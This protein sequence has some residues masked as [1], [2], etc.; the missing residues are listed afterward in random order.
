MV[1]L[2]PFVASSFSV[3]RVTAE[4]GGGEHGEGDVGIGAAL[5]RVLLTAVVLLGALVLTSCGSPPPTGV[6]DQGVADGVPR[7]RVE[8]L[9]RLPHDPA[10]FT[11]GLELARDT[12]FEGPGRTGRSELHALDPQTGAVR[13]RQGL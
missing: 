12:L 7:L 8:V 2:A 11:E 10:A 1:T 9:A 3:A 4:V 13:H 5:H 6:I